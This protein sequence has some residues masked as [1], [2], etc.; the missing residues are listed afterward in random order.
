[1]THPQVN[2]DPANSA[3]VILQWSAI[4]KGTTDAG[5]LLFA[6]ELFLVSSSRPTV[7]CES[8]AV[9]VDSSHMTGS[10]IHTYTLIYLAPKIVRTNLRRWHRMTRW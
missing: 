8:V 5:E 1:M 10:Y 9:A 6:A 2:L 7:H 4:K 3:Q